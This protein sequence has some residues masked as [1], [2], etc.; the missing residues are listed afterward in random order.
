MDFDFDAFNAARREE[1]GER[2]TFNLE[3][4]A[5][6]AIPGADFSAVEII[7]AGLTEENADF[8][9][10]VLRKALG[11]KQ[12]AELLTHI[13]DAQPPV[14]MDTLV[15]VARWLIGCYTGRP[16]APS[17]STAPG[18]ADGGDGSKKR[19]ARKESAA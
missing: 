2:P 10:R 13:R 3:G 14:L 7:E 17:L 6:T 4:K 1:R 9:H 12:Y 15:E 5:W 19:S 16:P 11:P 8:A 18:R